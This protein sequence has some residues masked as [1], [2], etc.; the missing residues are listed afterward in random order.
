MYGTVKGMLENFM[1]IVE[2]YGF[3]P[4]GGRVYYLM[5]S[6]PPL[7]TAMVDSYIQ[8]TNDYE[9][10][11]RHIGTLEKELHFWLSNH[12]TLVEKDGKEY[13]LAR[14][15]DM[16][17][18]PRPESY[19]E[20]IHSAAI[21]KT[22]EEKDDFYS[23]L[24]AAAESGWDFSSRWFI[25]NGTNQG[26]LTSTKVKKIIPVDLNAMIYW[27]ADL[28]SKFYKKLGNTVKAIEYGLLAA[29]WLEAVEKILWH[30]EVGAWLDYDLI[31]QMKRD[32]FYP[33]NLAPLWTGCYDPARKAYYLGHLLEYLRRSK[34]MVN[35]GALPTTLEHSGEQW[36]YPNA[37]APNQAIIIQGLQRLGT[38]E[39]EEMAAQ[40]ASKWVYTNYRGFEE[41]G[42]M[43]EKYNSE[44]VGSGGG[45]GEY[46]PQEGFGWTNGVIFE[47]L[48]Y[49][50]RYFR[51]TNRVGNKRG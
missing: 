20:D 1:T 8:A 24:K 22:E 13:T 47:L 29:E 32:Y 33:S 30:E 7:L 40:L 23:Q 4:N 28:L 18:G 45:G 37:W 36:D 15:Y 41:T 34:V 46:A 3:I 16:S 10:L 35:E 21:F 51:S 42:K 19:R 17:S 25:L 31:N 26:N 27:N 39:A 5:R 49:Y 38:R 2:R 14:Y 43:F 9:F 12:T 48:D 6:Q 44:L 11:D 50:G